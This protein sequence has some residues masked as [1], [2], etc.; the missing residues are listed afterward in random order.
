MTTT[1]PT[2]AT[3]TPIITI[4][5]STLTVPFAS[6]D[7][8]LSPSHPLLFG[9]DSLQSSSPS[10]N[11]CLVEGHFLPAASTSMNNL[12]VNADVATTLEE[13]HEQVLD[14][15]SV[16]KDGLKQ[17]ASMLD[18]NQSEMA[19]KDAEIELLTA[20]L[21]RYDA[22]L[23]EKEEENDKMMDRI[24]AMEKTVRDEKRA[25]EALEGEI[26]DIKEGWV[27]PQEVESW[28]EQIDT[29][30][31][32]LDHKD[33]EVA[34]AERMTATADA[35]ID[36]LLEQI[37]KE[38][39]LGAI[40]REEIDETNRQ[41]KAEREA[42]NR[43][44]E[45]L[46]QK[47]KATKEKG[48]RAAERA[49]SLEFEMEA[50]EKAL[51][52]AK[53]LLG[54]SEIETLDKAKALEAAQAKL[55]DANRKFDA[56]HSSQ[57]SMQAELQQSEGERLAIMGLLNKV[58]GVS[59][60]RVT[61]LVSEC[62]KSNER[63][64]KLTAEIREMEN[65][66]ASEKLSKHVSSISANDKNYTISEK[67]L[68]RL[69]QEKDEELQRM[70]KQVQ[71]LQI[72]AASLATK[73][74]KLEESMTDSSSQLQSTKKSLRN[75]RKDLSKLTQQVLL[76]SDDNHNESLNLSGGISKRK[77]LDLSELSKILQIA[78]REEEEGEVNKTPISSPLKNANQ[79]F[80]SRTRDRG[81]S[82]PQ[83]LITSPNG[84][85]SPKG[86]AKSLEQLE[87]MLERSRSASIGYR[88][89]IEF[90][91]KEISTLEKD[92]QQQRSFNETIVQRLNLELE[93]ARR[94]NSR[95]Q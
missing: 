72:D 87:D 28:K 21:S 24:K 42:H 16:L 38:R 44:T 58:E 29:I 52:K 12:L 22:E 7:S 71:R 60:E 70:Q 27:P 32:E 62:A 9:I 64:A 19:H 40:T 66:L 1:T 14:Y 57:N 25:R 59:D 8:V 53:A 61:L 85:Q 11:D 76:L 84:K 36:S 54:A 15:C 20:R 69:V 68:V 3:T 45:S 89:H 95:L 6:V 10:K 73:H 75:S 88:L 41:V 48:R 65:K 34:D 79:L 4:P 47:L 67:Q 90:L 83:P 23:R 13:Q 93:E 26:R 31:S 18:T 56:L 33:A 86:T 82:S 46:R 17:L 2:T 43:E 50:R 78:D 55:A 63:V 35:R 81:L 49:K 5:G 77:S 30:Q 51:E 80:G 91:S 92:S 39:D 74:R 37:K 94:M